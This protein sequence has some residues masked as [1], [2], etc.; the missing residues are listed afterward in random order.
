M[1]PS[2]LRDADSIPGVSYQVTLLTPDRSYDLSED[3]MNTPRIVDAVDYL[4]DLSYIN[5]VN[6]ILNNEDGK[7]FTEEGSGLLIGLDEMFSCELIIKCYVDHPGASDYKVT[8]FAGWYDPR[9]LKPDMMNKTVEISA[10]NYFG[11]SQELDGGNICTQY[12]DHNGLILV[13]TGCWLTNAAISDFI[14]L[15]GVHLIETALDDSMPIGK[16]RLDKGEWV[17]LTP[18]NIATLYNRDSNQA[19][20]VGTNINSFRVGSSTLIVNN[21]GE[22][23]PKTFYFYPAAT[24]IVDKCFDVMKVNQRVI[25]AFQIPTIDGRNVLSS[26]PLLPGE[27]FTGFPIS[28][29]SNGSNKIYLSI[30]AFSIVGNDK[31]QVWEIDFAAGTYVKRYETESVYNDFNQFKLKLEIKLNGTRLYAFMKPPSRSNANF[32]IQQFNTS[33]WDRTQSQISSTLGLSRIEYSGND[34]KFLAIVNDGETKKIILHDPNGI[35]DDDPVLLEDIALKENAFQFAYQEGDQTW[36]YFVKEVF[37]VNQIWRMRRTSS[38]WHSP[39]FVVN[40]PNLSPNTYRGFQHEKYIFLW[41]DVED[42]AYLLDVHTND[43]S[44]NVCDTGVFIRSPFTDPI[45]GRLYMMT[46]AANNDPVADRIA[47]LN[48]VQ[49]VFEAVAPI[50]IKMIRN[51]FSYARAKRVA[52]VNDLYGGKTNL[53][54]TWSPGVLFRY[55]NSFVP[56]IPGE[57]ETVGKTIRQLLQEIANNYLAWIKV[58]VNKTGYFVKRESY[59]N[60]RSFDFSRD[61]V[62]ARIS[63]K[64]YTDTYDVVSV[65]VGDVEGRFGTEGVDARVLFL[66]LDFIPEPV[67]KDMAKYFHDYYSVKRTLMRLEYAP[68]YFDYE[69]LDRV[70]FESEALPYA[71]RIHTISPNRESLELELIIEHE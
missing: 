16:G 20:Q 44:E 38:G 12:L 47:Y 30:E 54:S 39:E 59:A 28:V 71:S 3:I 35:P 53:V 68:G 17:E 1:I 21:E 9:K 56:T 60:E 26:F 23:Y 24:T 52:M 11:A 14:L 2:H 58:D 67:A 7:Y 70:T 50:G 62:F 8:K 42:K 27:L 15:N 36:F 25:D 4:P 10:F 48:A 45:T 57:Y 33:T 40:F 61:N 29:V 32:T 5:E 66:Q 63:E 6:L 65:R 34:D 22:Q 37:T 19:V 31:Y 55:G 41:S 69:S 49:M 64:L 13:A 18:G 51:S 46:T 43:I